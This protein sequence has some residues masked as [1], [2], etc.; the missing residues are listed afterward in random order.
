MK[1]SRTALASAWMMLCAPMAAHATQADLMPQAATARA[2]IA[3]AGGMIKAHGGDT[4]KARDVIVDA[5]GTEHVRMQRMYEGL[6]VIGGDVV[7]HSRHGR[8]SGA[9]HAMVSEARPAIQPSLSVEAARAA[10]R[11]AFDG[12]IDRV[13]SPEMVIF[14]LD[15]APRLAY[16]VRV[17]GASTTEGDAHM[18]YFVDAEDGRILEHWNLFQRVAASG[19]AQTLLHGKVDITTLREDIGYVMV[20]P[21]RGHNTV[22]DLNHRPDDA[23]SLRRAKLFYS[24]TNTWGDHAEYDPATVA[25]DIAYGVATTWDYFKQVHGRHG[26]ANNGAG[27]DAYANALFS[28]PLQPGVFYA[29]NAAWNGEAMLFG[30]GDANTFPLVSLDVT[31]HEMS[32][33]VVQHTAD[34][35]YRGES[36]GLNESTADI[37]GNMVERFAANAHDRP[38]YLLGEGIQRVNHDGVQALRY[39]FKPSLDGH[40]ADCW[41][42]ELNTMEVHSS[43]GVGNH[44]FYLL[45]EGNVVPEGFGAGT[46]ANLAPR[47]LLCGGRA[48]LHGI[49]HD[50]AQ[51]I[52]YRALT[53]Y[54]TSR[55]D[56]A[57]AR[58]AT[59]RAA[60]DL[61]GKG[62][63]ETKAVSTAWRAVG[64]R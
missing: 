22:L 51:R 45:A 26:V 58:E 37:F 8:L 36:G 14:A 59:L 30:S 55:T 57:G 13:S 1:V 60:N 21:G 20:D 11:A 62:S 24:A 18:R 56:Y 29:T 5:D 50:A 63:T 42:P 47:D 31:G 35:I 17:K 53:I 32:H 61:Y 19:T 34:L 4:F 41:T 6:R 25:G 10:A 16:E 49:G 44:F 33:G 27:I 48:T 2:L 12:R 7:I 3:Q 52:W 64:V 39:M 54:M 43:S 23:L 40:S 15:A 38:D 9:S 46:A 28:S